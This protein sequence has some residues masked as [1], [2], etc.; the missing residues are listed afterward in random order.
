M[1]INKS[2][3]KIIYTQQVCV[4]VCVDKN[5]F[6]SMLFAK[7]GTEV[8]RLDQHRVVVGLNTVIAH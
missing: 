4:C 5:G 1:E 3:W 7:K 6:L 2:Q 8:K